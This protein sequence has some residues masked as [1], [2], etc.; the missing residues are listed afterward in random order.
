MSS[1]EPTQGTKRKLENGEGDDNGSKKPR[2]EPEDKPDVE[3]GEV[4]RVPA[5]KRTH[6]DTLHSRTLKRPKTKRKQD[7]WMGEGEY[8][9]DLNGTD[10]EL[11]DAGFFNNFEDDFNDDDL[12]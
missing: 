5:H 11:V 7:E 8:F 6:K 9:D 3:M 2:L 1:E 12:A 4:T 10:M